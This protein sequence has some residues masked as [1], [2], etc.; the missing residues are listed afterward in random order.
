MAPAQTEASR[1]E[2]SKA[3]KRWSKVMPI[4]ATDP[5]GAFPFQEPNLKVEMS[6]MRLQLRR[7]VVLKQT[8][9][10]QVSLI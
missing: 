1:G 2:Q 8:D 4:V 10:T 6:G 3:A 7:N 5:L 9:P